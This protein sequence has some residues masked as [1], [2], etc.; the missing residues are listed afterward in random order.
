LLT[1][2]PCSS[3]THSPDVKRRET[4][5]PRDP[6]ANGEQ[7]T[8]NASG[9]RRFQ[10]GQLP[11]DDLSMYASNNRPL[12]L[13]APVRTAT[14]LASLSPFASVLDGHAASGKREAVKRKVV[15]KCLPDEG[16]L[17]ML[18]AIGL[19]KRS[20]EKL[21]TEKLGNVS[22]V[23]KEVDSK[24]CRGGSSSLEVSTTPDRSGSILMTRRQGKKRTKDQTDKVLSIR[25]RERTSR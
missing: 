3:V 5:D 15:R 24:R 17:N 12:I 18:G 2:C 22:T 9:C 13:M 14:R 1:Q 21:E 11:S 25:R 20:G 7:A 16:F 23:F 6:E 4:C 10:T 8:N 19:A